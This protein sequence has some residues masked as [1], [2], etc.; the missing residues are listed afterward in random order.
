[1]YKVTEEMKRNLVFKMAILVIVTLLGVITYE[2]VSKN[3]GDKKENHNYS[4]AAE[5]CRY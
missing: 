4:S 2:L 5:N 3:D 1:M